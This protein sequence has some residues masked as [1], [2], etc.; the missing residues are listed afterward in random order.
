MSLLDFP[1]NPEK[2]MEPHPC[3]FQRFFSDLWVYFVP[4][5]L[6]AWFLEGKEKVIFAADD[7][8][9]NSTLKSA[10]SLQGPKN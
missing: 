7:P 10:A 3:V 9:S 1:A 4:T 8:A 5:F 6:I 2:A